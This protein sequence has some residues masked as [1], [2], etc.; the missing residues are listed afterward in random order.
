MHNTEAIPCAQVAQQHWLRMECLLTSSKLLDSGHRKRSKYT[1]T[2][3]LRFY[4]LLPPHT[5]PDAVAWTTLHGCNILS[6]SPTGFPVSC[7]RGF[8][9]V[10]S[11]DLFSSSSK[12]SPNQPENFHFP[13]TFLIFSF[14]TRII[15]AFI[16]ILPKIFFYFPRIVRV[17]IK[18]FPRIY[19]H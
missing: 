6:S 8:A 1:F 17:F 15:Q 2:H 18:I 13:G 5:I 11:F 9:V 16:I 10:S 14:L 4:I 7:H 12:F 3:T 19:E